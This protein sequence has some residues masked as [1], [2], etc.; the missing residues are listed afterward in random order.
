MNRFETVGLLLA[1]VCGSLTMFDLTAQDLPAIQ[2]APPVSTTKTDELFHRINTQ[3]LPRLQQEVFAESDQLA[4]ATKVVPFNTTAPTAPN[5]V[6]APIGRRQL[7]IR[8]R[9]RLGLTIPQISGALRELKSEG[10][11]DQSS[12]DA[13][14]AALVV[15]KLSAKNTAAWND[16]NMAINLEAIIAFIE[17]LIP[18]IMKIIA[19]F[20]A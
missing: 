7:T 2:P 19:L 17:A 16:S 4:Q 3:V 10:S 14:I 5:E 15:G 8:D 11:I 9:M 18:L 12:S 13:E 1:V 20:P 6:S